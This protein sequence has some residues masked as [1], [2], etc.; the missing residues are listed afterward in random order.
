MNLLVIIISTSI[1]GLWAASGGVYKKW[2]LNVVETSFIFNLTILAAATL[3]AKLAGG[4]QAAVIYSSGSVAF[5][6]FIGIITYHHVY[7]RMRDSRASRNLVRKRNERRRAGDNGWEREDAAAD[8]EMEEM[9]P[10]AAPTVTYIEI[11]TDERREMHP[12][13]PP[14]PPHYHSPMH[15]NPSTLF[16]GRMLLQMRKWKRCFHKFLLL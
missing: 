2:Y 6:T 4:N 15:V 3:Y 9:L 12:I 1:L 14:P 11:P 8:D 5:S 7:H 13:T 10:Q 16:R